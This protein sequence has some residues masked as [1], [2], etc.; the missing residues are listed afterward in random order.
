MADTKAQIEAEKW[1][2]EEYLPKKYGQTFRQESLDLR[3]KGQFNPLVSD[4]DVKRCFSF[5]RDL[6]GGET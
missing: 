6:N 2:R 5:T 1:I 3:S 4:K